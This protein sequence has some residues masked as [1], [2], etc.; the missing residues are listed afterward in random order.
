MNTFLIRFQS[1]GKMNNVR[2]PTSMATDPYPELLQCI[3]TQTQQVD[4]FLSFKSL[5]TRNRSHTKIHAEAIQRLASLPR[6]ISSWEH[7]QRQNKE[8]VKAHRLILDQP[9]LCLR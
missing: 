3:M 2:T 5:T 1:P 7:F 8:R 6:F 9:Q 4:V